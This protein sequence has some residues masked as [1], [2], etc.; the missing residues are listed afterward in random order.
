MATCPTFFYDPPL[1]RAL[2]PSNNAPC[3]TTAVI[4]APNGKLL[5]WARGETAEKAI[6]EFLPT[7]GHWSYA[8]SQGY[9]VKWFGPRGEVEDESEDVA[10]RITIGRGTKW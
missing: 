4:V 2:M 6:L 9:R 8:R 10:G 5:H 7:L 3:T 1:A